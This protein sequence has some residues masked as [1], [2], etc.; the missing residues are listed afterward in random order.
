MSNVQ[1]VVE[2]WGDYVRGI[3]D[4]QALVQGIK[5]KIGGCGRVF[6]VPNPIDR[7]GE[8]FAIADMR[9]LKLSEPHKHSGETEI[10]FVL[11]GIGS[12]AVGSKILE[13]VPG[14][15]VVTP[16]DTVHITRPD[17][18]LVLGVVNTP[19]FEM[20]NYVAVD[21]EEDSAVADA[22]AQL[23]AAA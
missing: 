20:D 23:Q 11:E 21:P 4:W 14:A 6:D 7:P 10:Y 22:I 19:P 16:P 3:D 15:V 2:V 17:D 18:G 12:I 1:E 13:L 8:S 5:P 9:G